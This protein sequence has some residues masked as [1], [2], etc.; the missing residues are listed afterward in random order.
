MAPSIHLRKNC[1]LCAN[2]GLVPLWSLERLPFTDTIG[3]Y[4]I[5]YPTVNQTLAICGNCGMVQLLK[6]VNPN[7]L[8]NPLYYTYDRLDSQK[9]N[10]EAEIYRDLL[11]QFIPKIREY[12][13]NVLEIGGSSAIFLNKIADLFEIGFIIDPSPHFSNPTNFKINFITGFMEDNFDIILE[14]KINVI[15]CRH[16]IEH[17]QNPI[18]FI[19]QLLDHLD[20]NSLLIFETPNF[21]SLITKLRFDAIFHQHLNY[22]SPKTFR[23]MIETA[24]G[25]VV[26]EIILKNGSNGGVMIF[27]FRKIKSGSGKGKDLKTDAKSLINEFRFELSRFHNFIDEIKATID[28][29]KGNF[30][31]LGAGS[32][33]PNLNYHLEGRIEYGLGVID[34]DVRKSGLGYRN[35]KVLIKSPKVMEEKASSN[36][37]ITSLENRKIL[38]LRAQKLGFKKIL[39]LPPLD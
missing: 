35:V 38:H 23:Y 25:S 30:Y 2:G 34:D 4:D 18:N 1:C 3:E 26:K 24:G 7:F 22:F 15:I 13:I 19:T 10:N 6:I 8:Y 33:L 16:V 31:G 17:I 11:N 36:C 29:F 14:N 12:A 39:F 37:L 9:I 27:V 5:G 28:S 20:D 21:N 32:L